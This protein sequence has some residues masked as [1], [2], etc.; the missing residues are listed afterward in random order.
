[1]LY[2]PYATTLS[3]P[4]QIVNTKSE[5]IMK[6]LQIS[7]SFFST[8][9]VTCYYT[10]NDY[11]HHLY[12]L[13]VIF[14]LLNH[15]LERKQDNSRNI[16]HIINIFLAHLAFISTLYDTYNNVFMAVSMFNTFTFFILEYIHSIYRFDSIYNYY[17]YIEF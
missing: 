7:V 4:K 15:N 11:Y 13:L 5:G 2:I 10:R 3:I 14:G 1:M 12:L 6:P 16:V 8:V 9:V 17:L